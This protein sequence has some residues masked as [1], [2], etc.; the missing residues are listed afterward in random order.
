MGNQILP[1]PKNQ[2][3]LEGRRSEGLEKFFARLSFRD[4]RVATMSGEK[5]TTAASS[6]SSMIRYFSTTTRRCCELR[7]PL[8]SQSHLILFACVGDRL[9]LITVGVE[10]VDVLDHPCSILVHPLIRPE[11][12][13]RTLDIW[14]CSPLTT[15]HGFQATVTT[16]TVPSRHPIYFCRHPGIDRPE[17]VAQTSRI[18]VH[19]PQNFV[20]PTLDSGAPWEC[21]ALSSCLLT[22]FRIFLLISLGRQKLLSGKGNLRCAR[23]DPR[24]LERWPSR[25]ATEA[26]KQTRIECQ[27]N[28][29]PWE[30]SYGWRPRR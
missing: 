10:Q 24:D 22:P 8:P 19:F 29:P 14:H 15:L 6:E 9:T 28:S 23:L 27:K 11:R 13:D 26:T 30:L 18:V 4:P 2:R 3:V 12:L 5:L 7:S 16:H 1:A 17:S 21:Y 20:V 25:L